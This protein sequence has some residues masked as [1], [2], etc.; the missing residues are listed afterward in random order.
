MIDERVKKLAKII[1]DYSIEVKKGEKVLIDTTIDDYSLAYAL[2]DEVYRKGGMPFVNFMDN[3]IMRKILMNSNAEM[4][5]LKAKY[6]APFM[7]D[8]DCY[9][10]VRGHL[11]VAELGDVPS[12]RMKEWQQEWLNPVHMK[13]RVPKKKW[14]VLR[15]PSPSFAQSANMPTEKFEE[16][17]FNVCTLDYSKMSKEMD[18][19]VDL[20]NKTDKVHIKGNGT[21]LTFSIK[22]IPAIK[23]DGKMNIPDGEVFTAPVKNSVNGHITYNARTL[24]QGTI[25]DE[26]YLE[27]KDGKIV[28]A[29]AGKKTDKLNKI[30]DTD[31]G[32]RYIGEFAIGLNP[33]VEEPMLDIL[34]D[35]KIKGSFHFTPGNAYDEADNGNRSAVHWDMVCIQRPEYGGGEI[36]FDGK[37]I[38]KDGLFVIPELEGLNPENLK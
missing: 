2:I 10:A 35:E 32:A 4:W 26:I 23:C 30:L 21:D 18:N 1:V 16:F 19:L 33:Y 8:M 17:F 38:R 36:Y 9:V 27:F 3:R 34:F 12:E 14:V 11:N 7:N 5:K 15:W 37:L 25:F 28:K 24:Y 13:I 29:D 31:E 6:D 20:M 22:D